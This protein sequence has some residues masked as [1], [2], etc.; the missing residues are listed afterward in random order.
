MDRKN[1]AGWLCMVIYYGSLW[2]LA[3]ATAGHV[4]HLL[5]IPGLAGFIMFP[6]GFFLMSRA[7]SRSGRFLAV[8]LTSWIAAGIK[9]AD[10]VLPGAD[11]LAVWNPAQAILLEGLTAAALLLVL[12]ARRQ[13]AFVTVLLASLSWRLGHVFLCLL[14]TGLFHA[15]NLFQAGAAFF[16]RFLL[17]DSLINGIL[18]YHLLKISPR[19]LPERTTRFLVKPVLSLS[20]LVAALSLELIL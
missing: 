6:M 11:I 7:F 10:L 12:K 18:L 19:Y 15:P 8:F 2:G 16:Y 5:R 13:L 1:Q 14:W 4:L 17:L 20:L 3:E 9:L